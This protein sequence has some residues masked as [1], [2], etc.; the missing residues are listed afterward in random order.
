MIALSAKTCEALCKE[1]QFMREPSFEDS[2]RLSLEIPHLDR[3][4]P[5]VH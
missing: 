1:A 2:Q 3:D 4:M 5:L